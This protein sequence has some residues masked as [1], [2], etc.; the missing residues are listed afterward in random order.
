MQETDREFAQHH[1]R[2]GFEAAQQQAAEIARGWCHCH[3][4]YKDRELIAPD[5]MVHDIAVDIEEMK[6]TK[7]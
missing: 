5:C 4:A 6:P 3:Q 7:G 2:L 1:Y